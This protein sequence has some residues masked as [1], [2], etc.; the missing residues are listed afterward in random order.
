MKLLKEI[1]RQEGIKKEGKTIYREAVRGIIINERK[2]LMIYSAKNGDYKFPGGGVE[3]DETYEEALIR[4]I[5]EECG[6]QVANVEEEFGKVIEYGIA[7]ESEID[8][9]KMA[10][11]YYICHVEPGLNEQS[12]DPYEKEL[13]FRPVW[14]EIDIAID[15]NRSILRSDYSKRPRWTERETFVLEQVKQFL[16]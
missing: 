5:Q 9:F 4:E 16:L 15:T 3:G 2:L 7:I 14:V 8:V 13:G 1:M 12:L 6:A 10:S 11:L